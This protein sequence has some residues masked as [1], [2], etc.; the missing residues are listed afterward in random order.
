MGVWLRG[1]GVWA[2]LG[3]AGVLAPLLHLEEPVPLWRLCAGL[4]VLAAAVAVR[5]RRPTAALLLAAVPALAVAPA[6]FTVGQMPALVLLAY[7]AGLRSP[8]ARP[9]LL[10]F[11]VLALAGTAKIAFRQVDPVAEWLVLMATLLFGAVFPWLVGRYRRQGR[12]LAAAG[13][14]RAEQL[15]REHLIVADRARLRERARIAQD[16]HDSLGHE[17]SLIALRAGA[18]QV[19]AD[20]PEGRRAAAAELRAAASDA[21]DRLHHVIGLL[22]EDGDERAPLAPPGETVAALVARAT[23]SGLLVRLRGTP[24]PDDR[25]A[26]RVVQEALTNAA[27][28]AP[29]APVTVEA[30]RGAGGLTLTVT[31]GPAAAEEGSDGVGV[32]PGFVADPVAGSVAGAVTG[33][34]AGPVT[35]SVAGPVVGPV[36]GSGLGLADLR[37]RVLDLGGS[38]EAGPYAEGFRVCVTL[39]ADGNG[40]LALATPGGVAQ[41][42]PPAP[43]AGRRIRPTLALGVAAGAGTVLI[44]GAFTWYAYSASHTVLTPRSYDSLALGTPLADL[45]SILP[46]RT[47]ADPPEDRAPAA[48]PPGTDCRYY[49]ATGEL[50]VSV[51]HFRLCFDARAPHELV[52]KTLIPKA[53]GEK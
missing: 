34:V 44:A 29:G 12:E 35:G 43:A 28:H 11:C 48:S 7:L 4:V 19:A 49:R 24:L 9:P 51:D 45:R 1:A 42:A 16:M 23:D 13:W 14:A 36:R 38:F 5:R 15:E 21:T 39:P 41:G 2:G 30:E 3:A 26:Y 6:L 22:R 20:L 47:E 33:S 18:L 31:N 50:F 17:L 53:N 40:P 52:D 27:K 10:A 37:A 46:A 8:S 32:G 25:T